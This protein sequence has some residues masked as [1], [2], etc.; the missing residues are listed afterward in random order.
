[1]ELKKGETL[2]VNA[3]LQQ[4]PGAL[5]EIVCNRSG[6]PADTFELYYGSK[7]L[8]GEAVLAN[9]GVE[10]DSLI[11]VKTRGRG[12][13]HDGG[14]SRSGLDGGDGVVVS[15]VKKKPSIMRISRLDCRVRIL[16]GLSLR[17]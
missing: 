6:L 4:P 11:E 7:R 9:W 17:P 8:D 12:G 15:C 3:N 14:G 1:M 10:K 13:V 5:H 2:M 16:Q